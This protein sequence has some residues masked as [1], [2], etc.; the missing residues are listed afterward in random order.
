M[1]LQS[2]PAIEM[3]VRSDLAAVGALAI[4]LAAIS[5]SGTSN[6]PTGIVNTAGVG[7]V[8]G[9]TNGAA[10]T[11]DHLI[12]LMY[13]TRVNNAPQNAAGFALNSK[14][15]GFLSTL[16]STTGQYLWDPQG[17]LTN[18]SP[19]RLKGR[20]YAESQQLRSTLTKGTSSGICSELIY[21]GSWQELII[22]EW[23]ITEI[24]VN[25]Y[26]STG[27]VN[28]DVLLRMFQTIDIGVR[29]AASFAVMSDALTAG[30]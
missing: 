5:G 1:L 4:D 13:S 22:G 26:D 28:G 11:F 29:H 30:F 27:F 19:D 2:T 15:I 12:Q 21:G 24:A 14:T 8:I 25:P 9:G 16:K 20:P 7:S 6:Q 17:G 18:D 10:L 23:G 3:L